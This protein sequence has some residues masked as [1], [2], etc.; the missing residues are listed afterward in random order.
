MKITK[1]S[2]NFSVCGQIDKDDLEEL[3]RQGFQTLIGN[4]PDHEETDQPLWES[5]SN[6]AQELGMKSVFIPMNK[7]LTEHSMN[8][9]KETLK[10]D[11]GPFIAYCRSAR[12]SYLLY[13]AVINEEA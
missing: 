3:A 9:L 10:K 4:R 13:E 2:D 5:L 7:S 6:R 12:R 8:L 1:L 11:K